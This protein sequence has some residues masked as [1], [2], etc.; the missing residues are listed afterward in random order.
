MPLFWLSPIHH[1]LTHLYLPPEDIRAFARDLQTLYSQAQDHNAA[2]AAATR[3]SPVEA[4]TYPPLR[5]MWA[6]AFGVAPAA[7]LDAFLDALEMHVAAL[8]GTP[9]RSPTLS[10]SLPPPPPNHHT[11]LP[12]LLYHRQGQYRYTTGRRRCRGVRSDSS[13]PSRPGGP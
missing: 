13:I 8:P 3:P 4:I 6:Q 12:P 5:A 7:R 2:A 11:C 9:T 1:T 10:N